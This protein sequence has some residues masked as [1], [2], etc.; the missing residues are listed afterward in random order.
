[1][2]RQCLLLWSDC[3]NIWRRMQIMKF[4]FVQ[5][6][7]VLFFYLPH[8]RIF[9]WASYSKPA[10]YPYL[11]FERQVSHPCKITR[12]EIIGS[13][14]IIF[15]IPLDIKCYRMPRF[16]GFDLL[17]DVQYSTSETSEGLAETRLAV[18]D[19]EVWQRA[20]RSSRRHPR[21]HQEGK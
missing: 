11:L 8:V 9:S 10:S 3:Y 6:S 16:Y 4:F 17:Q 20:D 1:M 2:P 18:Q 15:I 5:F 12:S 19:Y 7:P 21:A 14:V 13:H